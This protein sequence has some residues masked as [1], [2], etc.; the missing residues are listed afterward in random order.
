MSVLEKLSSSSEEAPTDELVNLL[1]E[2]SPENL[3]KLPDDI[4]LSLRKKL[5]PYGRTIEGSNETLA[6]SFT[7]L[8]QKYMEKFLMTSMVGFLNRMN[9]EWNVPDGL[10]VIS[11][12]DYNETP[13]LLNPPDKKDGSAVTDKKLLDEYRENWRQMQKR[14]V[15]KEFLAHMFQYN[16][17]KHVRSAYRPNPADE[18]RKP[19]TTPAAK[20]A[21]K[22]L[23]KRDS[24]FREKMR[25]L[26]F[27]RGDRKVDPAPKKLNVPV[28]DVSDSP[29]MVESPV[30]DVTKVVTNMIPP[31]DML[32][33]WRFYQEVNFEELRSCVND[34]YCE[35]PEFEVAI[36]P[37]KMCKDQDEF[38]TFV[39]K[40]K[41][42]VI[43]KIYPADTGK[44]S[45]L[46]DFKENRK[47]MRFFN[48]KTHILE[49]I[50]A[51]QERDAK[52]GDE[53]MK[54]RIAIKKKKNIEEDGPDDPKFLKWKKNNKLL[55]SMSGEEANS[56]SYVDDD[57][58]DDAVQ[59]N[60]H[61]HDAKTGKFTS[62]KFF[63]EAEAPDWIGDT[64]NLE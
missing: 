1:N 14:C 18:D 7:N 20:L 33:R 16:P 10:P 15:V 38:N 31:Q 13:S 9:D 50:F 19:L 59:V 21:V 39:N 28:E 46:G 43:A 62:D 3:A 11:V 2:I 54:K 58:P 47:K 4:I 60:Y 26:E 23:K 42:E 6:F 63:T 27:K 44:W 52:M 53:L 30:S 36:N 29:E 57:C 32:H 34:L 37:Y 25:R 8:Q 35:K 48:E 61:V 49:E 51:Q 56:A 12:E 45:L 17:D 55:Q 24:K 41:N 40:H 64:P 5:N 22:V